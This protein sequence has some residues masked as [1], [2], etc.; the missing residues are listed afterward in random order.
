[1]K[2]N[3]KATEKIFKTEIKCKKF[4]YDNKQDAIFVINYYIGVL[5]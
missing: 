4:I 5:S 1:M 2:R 3:L